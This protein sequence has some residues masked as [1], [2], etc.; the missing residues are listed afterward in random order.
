MKLKNAKVGML[1]QAKV[2]DPCTLKD[3][4]VAGDIGIIVYVEPYTYKNKE[5][6][7][8]NVCWHV[9]CEGISELWTH[10]DQVRIYERA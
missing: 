2:D 8:I 9:A 1:V 3:K 4:V 7:G 10:H 6:Y 5:H